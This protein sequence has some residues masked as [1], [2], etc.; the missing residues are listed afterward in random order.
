[1][2]KKLRDELGLEMTESRVRFTI[3]NGETIPSLGR[4]I[5]ELGIGKEKLSTKVEVVDSRKKDLILGSD[6]YV[7][8]KGKIDY[9]NK[10]LILKIKGKEIVWPIYYSEKEIEQ[11]E[12]SEEEKDDKS[13]FGEEFEEEYDEM[14][15]NDEE[16]V[17]EE[18]YE[19]NNDGEQIYQ[20]NYVE[21]YR[22]YEW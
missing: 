11:E 21:K 19:E 9:E 10:K 18:D 2:S 5:V 13:D 16:R 12:L 14:K 1:M 8:N 22:E 17:M 15:W 6:F 20:L 7:R 4:V 3:A